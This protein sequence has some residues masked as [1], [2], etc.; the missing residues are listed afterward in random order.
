MG[1][2]AYDVELNIG[3]TS[4]SPNLPGLVSDLF[5]TGFV[6]VLFILS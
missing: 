3:I 4:I 1:A 2:V 6:P 5:F